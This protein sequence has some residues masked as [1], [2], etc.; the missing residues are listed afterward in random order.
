VLIYEVDPELLPPGA[1]VDMEQLTE[2][3]DRRVNSGS[4]PLAKV[5]LGEDRRVEVALMREDEADLKRVERLL[6]HTATLEFRILANDWNDKQLVDRAKA[7]PSKIL[8]VDGGGEL[9]AR[10]VPVK[11]GQEASLADYKDIAR[12]TKKVG[13]R[14]VMEVLV[15]KDGEELNGTYLK[16]IE[17]RVD[18]RGQARLAMTFN[19]RGGQLCRTLTGSHQPKKGTDRIFKLGI[20]I[21]GELYSAPLIVSTIYDYAQIGGAFSKQEVD[22]LVSRLNTG[23]LPARVRLA[24]KKDPP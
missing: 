11:S 15:V 21:N 7:D 8:V 23:S 24:E 14:E 5:R 20:I 13:Q 10:W 2:A 3:V 6:S 1:T 19:T 18:T 22:D 16:R 12:R 17:T 4:S 9:L